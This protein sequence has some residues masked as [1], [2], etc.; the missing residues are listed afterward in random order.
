MA[1]RSDQGQHIGQVLKTPVIQTSELEH[2]DPREAAGLFLKVMAER[3]MVFKGKLLRLPEFNI[4][5]DVNFNLALAMGMVEAIHSQVPGLLAPH[6][7]IAVS[8]IESSGTYLTFGFTQALQ[9]RVGIDDLSIHRIRRGAEPSIMLDASRVIAA[10]TRPITSS[11]LEPDAIRWLHAELPEDDDRDA[12]IAIIVDDVEA[13]GSSRR[14]AVTLV[15]E[16]FPS[17]QIVTCTAFRKSEQLTE[18]SDGYSINVSPLPIEHFGWDA[19]LGQA[20]L[21]AKGYPPQTL[22]RVT[23]TDFA[24]GK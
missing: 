11:L 23:Q 1:Y 10:P 18:T 9:K 6:A 2:L 21:I 22:R 4:R 5:P 16:M 24:I 19:D 7:K 20:V 13:T 12:D 17:A 8:A 14:G 15:R 3:A